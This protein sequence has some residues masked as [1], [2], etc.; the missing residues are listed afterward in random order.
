MK[1][2]THRCPDRMNIVRAYSAKVDPREEARIRNAWLAEIEKL[3]TDDEVREWFRCA[4]IVIGRLVGEHR[5]ALRLRKKGTPDVGDWRV[6]LSTCDD[7]ARL[8]PTKAPVARGDD[9]GGVT[10]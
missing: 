5:R 9:D 4:W 6:D 10:V 8:R 1:D 2:D 3:A 7:P